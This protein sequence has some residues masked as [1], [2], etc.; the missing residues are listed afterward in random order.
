MDQFLGRADRTSR[1]LVIARTNP[2]EE[3]ALAREAM[4]DSYQLLVN[5]DF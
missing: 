3:P 1:D 2:S 4:I 5:V